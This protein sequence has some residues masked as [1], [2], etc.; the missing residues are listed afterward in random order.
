MSV[1]ATLRRCDCE[2]DVLG[3][4]VN[5]RDCT[6]TVTEQQ[7]LH[8]TTHDDLTQLP[9][10]SHL[11]ARA[12]RMFAA[13]A[14]RPLARYCLLTWTGS[15]SL[16][17]RWVTA[18]VMWCSNKRALGFAPALAKDELSTLLKQTD[19]SALIAPEIA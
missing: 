19:F 4:F 12:A 18:L 3:F 8:Q 11:L 15:R 5:L 13:I 9:N 1:R 14:R 7:L 2:D 10:R 6:D 17:I 16:T